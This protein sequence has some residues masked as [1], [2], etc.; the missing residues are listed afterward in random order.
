M[1]ISNVKEKLMGVDFRIG[2][3]SYQRYDN[4]I[5]DIAKYFG[6]T[7][8]IDI[9]QDTDKKFYCFGFIEANGNQDIKE[10]FLFKNGTQDCIKKL[11][12]NP[13]GE[14]IREEVANIYYTLVLEK[15]NIKNDSIGQ[16]IREFEGCIKDGEDW[17]IS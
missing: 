5:T 17:Y 2:S 13:Y 15:E 6:G 4:L 12:N 3:M 7:P 11:C 10:K 1:Q 14:L 8:N 16:L 9:P